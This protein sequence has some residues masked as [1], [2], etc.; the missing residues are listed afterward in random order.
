[1]I[2]KSYMKNQM[3]KYN[4]DYMK[5]YMH[6]FKCGLVTIWYIGLMFRV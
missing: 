5:N 2:K 3:K 1:M 6:C 4:K